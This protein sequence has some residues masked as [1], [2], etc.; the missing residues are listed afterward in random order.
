MPQPKLS[1]DKDGG[2]ADL[3]SACAGGAAGHCLR[4]LGTRTIVSST[5]GP[6]STTSP[7]A[8][9]TLSRA[10]SQAALL[11]AAAQDAAAS[12]AHSGSAAS[13]A[14]SATSSSESISA[15][16]SVQTGLPQARGGARVAA[17]RLRR[18]LV[19]ADLT[20]VGLPPPARA[21]YGLQRR[22]R[23]APGRAASGTAG[24]LR[25]KPA[26]PGGRRRGGAEAGPLADLQRSVSLPAAGGSVQMSTFSQIA[27]TEEAVSS[28]WSGAD[29]GKLELHQLLDQMHPSLRPMAQAAAQK[30]AAER[31]VAQGSENAEARKIGKRSH[32]GIF[33]A[34]QQGAANPRASAHPRAS[35][36]AAEFYAKKEQRDR[37]AQVINERKQ[38]FERWELQ[39]RSGEAMSEDQFL[40]IL[41]EAEM[42]PR[43]RMAAALRLARA[44]AAQNSRERNRVLTELEAEILKDSALLLSDP[45]SALELARLLGKE[46][47][48]PN[49]EEMICAELEKEAMRLPPSR[50]NPFRYMLV[51]LAERRTSKPTRGRKE[52]KR[53]L[54]DVQ[55]KLELCATTFQSQNAQQENEDARTIPGGQPH[56]DSSGHQQRRESSWQAQP[57]SAQ[58]DD[59]SS[60][61]EEDEEDVKDKTSMARRR[62]GEDSSTDED[63][64]EDEESG[65]NGQARDMWRHAAKVPSSVRDPRCEVKHFAWRFDAEPGVPDGRLQVLCTSPRGMT[66]PLP[67]AHQHCRCS[68]GPACESCPP[69]AE[70]DRWVFAERGI[71]REAATVADRSMNVSKSLIGMGLQLQSPNEE[72]QEDSMDRRRSSQFNVYTG[73]FN[74]GGITD[75]IKAKAVRAEAVVKARCFKVNVIDVEEASSSSEAES[76]DSEIPLPRLGSKAISRMTVDRLRSLDA[77]LMSPRPSPNT[78]MSS[79]MRHMPTA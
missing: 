4:R 67:R 13:A 22:A 14:D 2:Q 21:L 56:G 12:G 26:P 78:K 66:R 45:H 36:L 49:L 64:D 46:L 15:A 53:A 63:E 69:A 77:C 47:D 60:A 70:R 28:T 6:S 38:V 54:R 31:T 39:L 40:C 65:Q 33:R 55:H 27:G 41:V 29:Q 57:L 37:E 23:A 34:S 1:K 48:R 52:M 9:R 19:H 5:P 8:A 10:A 24:A 30:R 51:D 73:D 20:Q 7:L 71:S 59:I 17:R 16:A 61:G 62:R 58:G 32:R 74:D 42:E 3:A 44:L 18:T 25:R 68:R 72:L 79:M 35:V 11:L 43:L 76:Q 50:T 75:R